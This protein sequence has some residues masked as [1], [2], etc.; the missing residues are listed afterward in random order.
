M[1]SSCTAVVYRLMHT[2]DTLSQWR[3]IPLGVGLVPCRRTGL[4]SWMIVLTPVVLS[5]PQ[6]HITNLVF[7]NTRSPLIQLGGLEQCESS[8]VLKE[9]TAHVEH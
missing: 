2:T 9:T 5:R 1:C 3:Q 6:P 8:F 7:V 4:A